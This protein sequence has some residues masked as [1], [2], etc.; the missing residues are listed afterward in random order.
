MPAE[1]RK[2]E[3]YVPPRP[4]MTAAERYAYKSLPESLRRRKESV[5]DTVVR[6][7]EFLDL[8]KEVGDEISVIGNKPYT[9]EGSG[10]YD[11]STSPS[12]RNCLAANLPASSRRSRSSTRSTREHPP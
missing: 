10:T 6:I 1:Q 3:K 4:E 12:A 5:D 2:G 7:L 11:P 8:V 9:P